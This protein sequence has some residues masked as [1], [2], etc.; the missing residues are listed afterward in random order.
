[1]RLTIEKLVPGGLGL[2]RTPD[3]VALVRGG[4]PGEVVEAELERRKNHWEGEVSEVLEPHPR[5]EEGP[6][7]PSVDLPLAYEAQLPIKAGFVQEALERIAKLEAA[8]EPI[9]PSPRPLGYR[10]AAQYAVMPGGGLAYRYPGTHNLL[11]LEHDPLLAPPLARAFGQL[12]PLQ[13]ACLEVALRGSLREGKVLLGLIGGDPKRLQ[14]LARDLLGSSPDVVGVTWAEDHPAGRF[15]GRVQ[16]LAGAGTLLEDFGGVLASVSVQGFAQVNP[17]AAGRMYLE[18]ARVAGEGQKAVELYAGSG[19]LGFHLARGFAEVVAVEISK[20]AVKRGEADKARLGVSNLR[21]HR[22]DAS[23]LAK[24]G[25]ADL[26]AVDPPRAGLSP[27][28]LQAL[29]QARPARLLYVSCD[30]AT[31]ARDVGRLAR[32]GYRLEFVRPYDFYPYT[33]HVEVLSLLSLA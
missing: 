15:R 24:L 27:Q 5:R 32:E 14:P 31:W 12:R 21:F 26:V 2:A 1:M 20:E 6:W 8:L 33:H 19:V 13:L 11:L 7:P 16:A 18:A 23:E 22:G 25:T 30:P 29:L 28:T 4:L 10:A 3:G 9:Q 17:E